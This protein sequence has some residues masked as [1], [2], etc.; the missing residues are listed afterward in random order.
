MIGLNHV[1]G[2][3]LFKK[4]SLATSSALGAV[5]QQNS[6]IPISGLLRRV[7]WNTPQH[8][9]HFEYF[10]RV[11]RETIV[12]R[13]G[14]NFASQRTVQVPELGEALSL[15]ISD[16]T[17]NNMSFAV[18]HLE[19]DLLEEAG[20]DSGGEKLAFIWYQPLAGATG[21]LTIALRNIDPSGTVTG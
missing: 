8:G 9:D 3:T 18:S 10:G 17:A 19:H 16:V 4:M 13:M 6:K 5:G 1:P 21:R 2:A 12:F 7:C 20:S 11:D 15:D 14:M